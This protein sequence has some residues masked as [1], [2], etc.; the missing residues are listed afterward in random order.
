MNVVY[1]DTQRPKE[2]VRYVGGKGHRQANGN[3]LL[4]ARIELTTS[5]RTVLTLNLSHCSSPY[6]LHLKKDQGL[7]Y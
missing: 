5:A 2:D 3:Y 1:A 4:G 7:A 6:I